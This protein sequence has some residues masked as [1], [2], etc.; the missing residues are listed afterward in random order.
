M[1]L[2]CLEYDRPCFHWNSIAAS[3]RNKGSGFLW[4][5]PAFSAVL[6]HGGFAFP[7]AAA[8]LCAVAR[9]AAC[10]NSLS[11]A[12]QPESRVGVRIQV[13]FKKD[14]QRLHQPDVLPPSQWFQRLY[15]KLLLSFK[16][17][18][19]ISFCWLCV[20]VLSV[21]KKSVAM[22]YVMRFPLRS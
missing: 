14:E 12:S 16:E 18:G 1:C 6:L 4:D 15:K 10:A 22:T 11:V 9:T 2:L 21:R 8:N 5:T 3:E 13:C 19:E 17:G 7:E 20:S